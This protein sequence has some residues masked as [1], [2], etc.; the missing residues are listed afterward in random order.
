MQ[1]LRQIKKLSKIQNEKKLTDTARQLSDLGPT[2]MKPSSSFK[3]VNFSIGINNNI[4]TN[5][6]VKM[7]IKILDE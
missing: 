6:K 4:T 7:K 2:K 3:W 5:I 1:K